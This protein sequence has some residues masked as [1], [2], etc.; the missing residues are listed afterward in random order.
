[1]RAVGNQPGYP[2]RRRRKK[3]GRILPPCLLF[4]APE[5]AHDLGHSIANQRTLLHHR[6]TQGHTEFGEFDDTAQVIGDPG[7]FRIVF[8]SSHC[9]H[10]FKSDLRKVDKTP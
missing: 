3:L 8:W 4:R 9:A 7:V 2:H 6:Q 10:P 5:F 1:M